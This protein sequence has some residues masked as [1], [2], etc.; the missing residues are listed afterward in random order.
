MLLSRKLGTDARRTMSKAISV[1]L[2]YRRSRLREEAH[3]LRF[4]FGWLTRR[5]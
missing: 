1:A 3:E 4:V 2:T 5:R